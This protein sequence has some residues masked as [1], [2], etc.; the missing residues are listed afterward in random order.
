MMLE[1]RTPYSIV[2][3]LFRNVPHAVPKSVPLSQVVCEA[4]Y[5]MLST[6]VVATVIGLTANPSDGCWQHLS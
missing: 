1:R 6:N 3:E 5:I 2:G 4:M